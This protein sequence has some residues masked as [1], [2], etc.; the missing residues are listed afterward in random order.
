MYV[1]MKVACLEE[2][3]RFRDF[4]DFNKGPET[5]VRLALYPL[6]IL[7][8]GCLVIGLV[9]QMSNE[10]IL[11]GTLFL[12][13]MSPLAYFIRESRKRRTRRRMSRRGAERTPLMP[14][15]EERQ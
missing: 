1:L 10:D 5:I 15:N 3:M 9:S 12:I 11:L 4:F 8:V 13:L 6:F 14:P 7:I 2:R